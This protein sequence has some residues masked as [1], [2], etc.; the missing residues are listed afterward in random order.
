M[1][2]ASRLPRALRPFSSGQY[3][4]L[5]AALTASLLSTGAWLVA[6][7]WQVVELGGTPDRPLVRRRRVEPRPACSPCSSAGSR[8]TAYPQRRILLA[9]EVVRGIGFAVAASAGVD[10]AHRGV[11]HRR[12]RVRARRRRRI[13]LP[14][15]LGV[16]ARDPARS[17]AARGERRRGRA[18]ADRDERRRSRARERAHRDARAVARLPRRRGAAGRRGIGAGGDAHDRSAPRLRRPRGA[19]ACVRRS[20]TCATGSPTCC[21]RAGSS[22]RSCSRPCSCSSSW[23]RSRCCSRSP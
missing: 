16:A 23:G 18:A 19:S 17:A 1:T 14:R 15:V 10:R 13:L 2:D 9:V 20:S 4:L 22:R 7:V 3:R 5:V 21:A 8:P 11:A 12:H 6:A